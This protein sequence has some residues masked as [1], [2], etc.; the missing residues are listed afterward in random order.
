M[1]ASKNDE[2]RPILGDA[3][4]LIYYSCQCPGGSKEYY[5]HG[6]LPLKEVSI[7]TT[8]G[9]FRLLNDNHVVFGPDWLY[10]LKEKLKANG[11]TQT[12]SEE[13]EK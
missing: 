7:N 6:A 12:I 5:Q 4:W 10:K 13:E 8:K 2:W 3:G 11:F 1:P 9:T